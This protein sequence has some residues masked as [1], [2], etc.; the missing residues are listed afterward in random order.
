[1]Q[2]LDHSRARATDFQ[3]TQ[4]EQLAEIAQI[5]KELESL[6]PFGTP[7][8]LQ[9]RIHRHHRLIM[10]ELPFCFRTS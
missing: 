4:E 10:Q 6:D 9:Y 1:M 7:S 8:V 3:K 5:S 2:E